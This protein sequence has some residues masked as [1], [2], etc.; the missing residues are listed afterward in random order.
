MTAVSVS[1]KD[2]LSNLST[3]TNVFNDVR[4][5]EN[6]ANPSRLDCQL[7]LGYCLNQTRTWLIA[8]DDY[9]LSEAQYSTFTS[10]LSELRG[11]KPLQ[12]I[13]GH[14]E[15]W[16]LDFQVNE[17][18]LIPRPETELLIDIALQLIGDSKPVIIDLGTGAGPI[19][20]A[21]SKECPAAT[22]I[23]TDFSFKALR[24]AKSNAARLT[25]HKPAFVQSNWLSCI[26]ENSVD[27]V[28]S[29][30]PYIDPNDP[31]LPQLSYEPATALIADCAGLADLQEIIQSSYSILKPKGSVIVEHGYDQQNAVVEL[32]KRCGYED[33]QP[34]LDLANQPRAVSA[35]KSV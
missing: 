17:S 32:F 15:F 11:G 25:D 20:V 7:L 12:Y 29:N 2:V 22:I 14:Q 6:T 30:P 9:V 31:H 16:S 24:C 10:H 3:H 5:D 26:T 1:V 27:L 18:T 8:H 23:A 21:L 19:A 34:F 35:R 4:T 33:I 28:I 13:L